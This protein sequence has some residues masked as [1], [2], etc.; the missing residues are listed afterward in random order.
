MTENRSVFATFSIIQTG[1]SYEPVT[2]Q[3]GHLFELTENSNTGWRFNANSSR[4]YVGDDRR[5][6]QYLSILSFDTSSLPDKA[7]ILTATLNVKRFRTM[8]TDPFGTHGNLGVE[9]GYPCFGISCDLE[10]SDFQIGAQAVAGVLSSFSVDNWH[11]AALGANA[12]P[13]IDQIG[14]TQFRL[15]FELSDNDDGSM[16]AIQ[17]LSGDASS[18][19]RPHLIVEYYVP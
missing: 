2:L 3:D 1:N 4:I 6:R 7:V 5:D 12:F 18:D 11:S 19:D 13:Y 16:N 8:G 10:A 17:F 9:I 15:R 14:T